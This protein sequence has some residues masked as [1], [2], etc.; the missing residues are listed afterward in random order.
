[1][2]ETI[3]DVLGTIIVLSMA[4]LLAVCVVCGVFCIFYYSWKYR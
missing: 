2:F 4:L 1:M 3:F